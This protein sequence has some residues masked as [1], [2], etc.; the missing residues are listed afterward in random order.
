ML[1]AKQIIAWREF[2][3]GMISTTFFIF[4]PLH[5]SILFSSA[6]MSVIWL[7]SVGIKSCLLILLNMIM[8]I[9]AMFLG[10]M[11][12]PAIPL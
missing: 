6:F 10:F 7:I 2:I 1:E 5:D 11:L 8:L 4:L 12:V 9:H 3:L